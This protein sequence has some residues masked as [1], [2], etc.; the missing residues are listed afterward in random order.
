MK[1]EFFYGACTSDGFVSHFDGLLRQAK[2]VTVLKGGCGCGK[3]TL[4]RAVAAAAEQRGLDVE[5]GLCS[6]DAGSLDAVYLP[7]LSTA[8][9]DGTA[10]HVL[11]PRL[12]G[13]SMNYLNFGEFYD[14]EGM[15]AREDALYETQTEN[16]AQYPAMYASLRAAEAA[17]R[18]LT[19]EAP[20]DRDELTGVAEGLAATLLPPRDAVGSRRTCFLH[21][22]VPTALL[23][24][25]QTPR[26]LCRRVV[27]LRDHYGQSA[28]LLEALA[29]RAA[30]NGHGCIVCPGLLGESIAHLLI[31]SAQAAFVTET[32]DFPFTGACFCRVELDAMLPAARRRELE[33]HLQS[34]SAYLRRAQAHIRQA[35]HLHDRMEL[36]CR[37]CVD[38]AAVERRTQWE[39][40]RL[41]GEK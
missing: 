33:P 32:D 24:L 31:P 38:F 27:V 16:A 7:A 8:Y 25:E 3:S 41:F 11:E 12:C 26:T 30:A 17:Q 35:K 15:R 28:V 4:M 6:S 23:L 10:P 14:A 5:L 21:A 13:G 22:V 18:C 39:L 29:R 2:H 40:N 36:L 1:T 19:A 34:R 9:A 20:I 37:P